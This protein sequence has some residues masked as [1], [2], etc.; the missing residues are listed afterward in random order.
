VY[1]CEYVLDVGCVLFVGNIVGI[2]CGFLVCD[3]FELE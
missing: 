2:D 3:M 1:V